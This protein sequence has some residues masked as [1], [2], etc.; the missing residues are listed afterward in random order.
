MLAY[1]SMIRY[2][3]HKWKEESISDPDRIR[4]CE[5]IE[6]AS[7]LASHDSRRSVSS[8]LKLSTRLLI[9]MCVAAVIFV[10][11]CIEGNQKAAECKTWSSPPPGYQSIEHFALTMQAHIFAAG[12]INGGAIGTVVFVLLSIISNVIYK[13]KQSI[14]K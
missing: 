6:T 13:K 11:Y 7:K 8:M 2:C 3:R 4:T 14:K 1:P 5:S 10:P 12:I 9:A